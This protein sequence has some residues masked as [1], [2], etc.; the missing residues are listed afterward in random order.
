MWNSSKD[1]VGFALFWI[2]PHHNWLVIFYFSNRIHALIYSLE[3]D[4]IA[5]VDLMPV[6]L[7]GI[8]FGVVVLAVSAK[9]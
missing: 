7:A 2:I 9:K 5:D 1:C 4:G 3:Q 6:V 8:E